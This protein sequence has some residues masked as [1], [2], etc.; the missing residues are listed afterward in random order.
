[1]LKN[2]DESLLSESFIGNHLQF[3]QNIFTKW[4]NTFIP[5]HEQAKCL[6]C[7]SGDA[8]DWKSLLTQIEN[9]FWN[10]AD[11]KLN[12]FAHKQNKHIAV[13]NATTDAQDRLKQLCFPNAV[14]LILKCFLFYTFFINSMSEFLH[15]Y[16]SI[17][18]T[19]TLF[20]VERY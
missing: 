10:I 4:F 17:E 3:H 13:Q 18:K 12:C 15:I 2:L 1:M 20:F 9:T 6:G 11:V 7:Y 8:I 5:A 16:F 14:C 19:I